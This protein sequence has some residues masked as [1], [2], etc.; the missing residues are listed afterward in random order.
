MGAYWICTGYLIAKIT[1][2]FALPLGISNVL[3]SLAS[4]FLVLQPIGGMI[5]ARVRHRRR[6]MIGMNAI[7]RVSICLVFFAVLLPHSVGAAVFCLALP[8][9]QAFQ[10]ISSPAYE[11][12]HVQAAE[13]EKSSNYYT[14]REIL[15]MVL[16]TVAT[17]AVQIIISLSE[18]NGN[19]RMG[20][21]WSGL[22]EAALLGASLVLLPMLSAPT[23]AV[24]D[25]GS[26]RA[27][28]A[29]LRNKVHTQIV[30]AN[31]MW[32]IANVFIG[33]LFGIYAV[34]I[35]HV[36]FIQ[37]MIWG[38]V[39]NVLRTLFAPVFPRI[40]EKIG[41]KNCVS[42]IFIIYAVLAIL[43]HF[44]N[45]QNAFW[46]APVFMSVSCLPTSGLSVGI[47][48]MRIATSTAEM[49]S[50]YFSVFSLISGV[51]SLLGVSL[52]SMLIQMIDSGILSFTFQD[53]FL[54][55]LVL[56]SIP[57]IMF[58]RIPLDLH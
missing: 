39:G 6:Y 29:V 9:M 46:I 15:F 45:L 14:V 11:D 44:S 30:V 38:T 37:I 54:I 41:W 23:D 36:D 55:G 8:V 28:V 7:W 24:S 31:A 12:W 47:L 34:R 26:L 57:F 21:V 25:T 40:A 17:A 2:Y 5:Y 33:G 56:L 22:I 20:F 1:E 18:H 32:C 51:A 4:T 42:N 58:R 53:L 3:T 35:L 13:K 52:S 19:L 10:Q 43:L 48:R 27:F 16:Y 50:V 49:R